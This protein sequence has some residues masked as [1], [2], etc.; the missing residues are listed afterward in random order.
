[1]I[2]LDQFMQGFQYPNRLAVFV[3]DTGSPAGI[4][5]ILVNDFVA[6]SAVV[7]RTERLAELDAAHDML[8]CDYPAVREFHANE[9]RL[10][11]KGWAAFPPEQR[12]AALAFWR[13]QLLRLVEIVPYVYIGAE[14]FLTA[15]KPRLDSAMAAGQ[16]KE[17]EGLDWNDHKSITRRVFV[18]ALPNWLRS[19]LRNDGVILTRDL[20]NQEPRGLDEIWESGSGVHMSGVFRLDSMELAGLQLADLAA[21]PLT[22]I[23][24][25]RRL[26]RAGKRLDDFDQLLVDL[27][28]KS[29]R[30]LYTDIL[31][32]TLDDLLGRA[33]DLASVV[34]PEIN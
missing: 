25:V 1:M 26:L 22:R 10:G 30:H 23:H 21:Y 18:T 7:V 2:T 29:G 4:P 32:G 3:D 20:Q 6:Y 5:G 15:I 28:M 19:R 11:K 31:G 27:L 33:D 24:Y 9:V 14:Q 8:L 34:A 17:V 16:I 12:L 13:D